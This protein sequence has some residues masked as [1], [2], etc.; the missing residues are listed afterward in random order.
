MDEQIYTALAGSYDSFMKDVPYEAWAGYIVKVLRRHQIRDGLVCDLGC[1]TGT[2]TGMLADRGYDMT[3]I[4]SSIEML[5]RAMEKREGRNILYLN[6]DIR[7]FELYGTMRAILA[8]CDTLN[9]L[10]RRKDLAKVFR[11]VNNYLDP[12]GVF[13]FD[14]H[15]PYYYEQ[16]L[17]NRTFSE[18]GEEHS[19]IWENHYDK[20][21]RRNA[22]DLTLFDRV[23]IKQENEMGSTVYIKQKERHVETAFPRKLVEKELEKAG[24]KL[25][26]VTSDYSAR[27]PG[28]K[29]TRLVYEAVLPVDTEKQTAD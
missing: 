5:D 16:V 1:G 8:A 28:R 22:Y 25:I 27:K 17:G 24:L 3:G 19:Y 26:R 4:D 23:D 12:G 11:L 9:Y 6:Q 20:R 10:P 18:E 21:K 13:L 29:S 2:L 7:E 15:T 14:L